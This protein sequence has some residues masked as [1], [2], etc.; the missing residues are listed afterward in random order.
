MAELRQQ[1]VFADKCG[2]EA[3]LL[4]AAE[5]KDRF[6]LMDSAGVVGS[7]FMPT[8]GSA[9]APVLAERR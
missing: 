8:D 5:T 4:S 7:I 3:H 1:K 6:P 2:L 9:N